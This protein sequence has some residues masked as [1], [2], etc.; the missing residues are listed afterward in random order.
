MTHCLAV[1]M[2][3]IVRM[4]EYKERKVGE[5][6]KVRLFLFVFLLL[7][8]TQSAFSD[9]VT[10]IDNGPS[11][12]RVDI[13]ILGDGYTQ[14]QIAFAYTQHVDAFIKHLFDE[15][16]D[17]YPRYRKFFNIHRVDLVSNE[18]GSDVPPEGIFRNTALDSS[19]YFDKVNQY[20]L[21]VNTVK[22][23]EILNRTFQNSSFQPEVKLVTVN[24]TRAGGGGG[25]FAVFAGGYSIGPEVALHEMGHAFNRL[26]DEYGGNTGWYAGSEPDD[27][28]VT[29]F[30]SGLKWAEWLGYNQPGVGVIGTYEGASYYDH[31]IYSPSEKSKMRYLGQPFNAVCREK[32]IQD[33]YD[34][35]RPLDGWM[36]NA[37]SL[38]NPQSIWVKT[39][40]PNVIALE[41]QVNGV[42]IPEAKGEQFVL[43]DVGFAPGTYQIRVRAY[44]PTDWVRRGREKLEQTVAWTVELTDA[45]AQVARSTENH[46]TDTAESQQSE[47]QTLLSGQVV[48][49]ASIRW[50]AVRDTD[51]SAQ[52]IDQQQVQEAMELSPFCT[53]FGFLSIMGVFLGFTF[54]FGIR[55]TK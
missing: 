10:V 34:R 39:S 20:S 2:L 25:S 48:N 15:G 18:S 28:N 9:Y 41:W 1:L 47:T 26:A 55:W 46:V 36:D 42:V 4:G 50:S 29:T 32:I 53:S 5:D 3:Q 44:D 22:A 45:V 23:N 37:K 43:G 21:Y 33:I 11:S 13:V 52:T 31:G 17:P 27:V 12:N 24:S 38:Q 49:T 7:L 16:E 35:I 30:K 19:Y 14:D 8:F 6:H 51:E 54:L 40:D